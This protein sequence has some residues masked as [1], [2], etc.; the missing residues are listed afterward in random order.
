MKT[1]E[2]FIEPL[3]FP[4]DLVAESVDVFQFVSAK[5]AIKAI[6]EYAESRMKEELINAFNWL[7][8]KNSPYVPLYDEYN[9]KEIRFVTNEADFTTE[10]VVNSY[11]ATRKNK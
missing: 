6:E 5:D 3:I 4:D 10:Q 1:A 11:L 8:D 7:S 2:E 9:E